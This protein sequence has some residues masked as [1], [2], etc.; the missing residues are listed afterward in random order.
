MSFLNAKNYFCPSNINQKK[1]TNCRNQTTI[2]KPKNHS[3]ITLAAALAVAALI[4][5]AQAAVV[6]STNGAISY[7]YSASGGSSTLPPA[8]DATV[9]NIT[10]ARYTQFAPASPNVRG[11]TN[12]TGT[13][14]TATWHFQT[15][16]GLNFSN[17]VNLSVG[18]GRQ[19]SGTVVGGHTV[20][21][22]SLIHH[23]SPALLWIRFIP[24]PT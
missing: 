9:S 13:V 1:D 4:T 14:G 15:S 7:T 10:I 23:G 19:G 2:M 6:F 18:T 21:T 5:S 22:T 12:V 16:A 8:S 3:K 11:L 20:L 24:Q 17:N